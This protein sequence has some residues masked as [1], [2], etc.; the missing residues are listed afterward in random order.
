MLFLFFLHA[1]LV[2][3]TFLAGREHVDSNRLVWKWYLALSIGSSYMDELDSLHK[4][5]MNLIRKHMNLGSIY[6]FLN[7]PEIAIVKKE[8]IDTIL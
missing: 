8:D 1:D 7:P 6:D 5:I 3:L 4:Q 2:F